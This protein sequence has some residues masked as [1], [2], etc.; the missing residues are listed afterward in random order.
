MEKPGMKS[1]GHP[2][3]IGMTD[4]QMLIDRVAAGSRSILG[5]DPAEL[6]GRPILSLVDDENVSEMLVAF[7]EAVRTR[8]GVVRAIGVQ[9]KSGQLLIAEAVVV[10][11]VPA[12]SS[13][14]ALVP[15][16][17]ARVSEIGVARQRFVQQL[18]EGVAGT[19]MAGGAQGRSD[20][21]L[22]TQRELEIVRR[23]VSGDRVPAIA[24]RMFLS[25]STI[26][27]HL[28]SVFRKF[29]MR[30]QQEIVD[31]FRTTDFGPEEGEGD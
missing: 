8:A 19:A 7:E 28:S 24:A 16:G 20:L 6:L 31:H 17:D 1:A 10:P 3:V 15:E 22:L 29:G 4:D 9:T 11:L 18:R 12:P 5:Y 27:S 23:V 13:A 14:F 26:R 25:P 30:S 2:P 21:S